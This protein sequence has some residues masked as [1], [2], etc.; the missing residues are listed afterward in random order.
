M[1]LIFVGSSISTVPALPGGMSDKA[2]HLLEYAGLGVLTVRALSGGRWEGVRLGAVVGTALI[3]AAYGLS[4]EAH[5]LLMPGRQFD[6]RD[7]AA[8]AAGATAAAGALWA[9]GIIR[10]FS[11]S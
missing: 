7:L 10:R 2:A 3:A 8:D 4:D 6:L 1:G 11:A 9:W 5:Q